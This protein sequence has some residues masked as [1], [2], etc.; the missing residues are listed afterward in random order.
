MLL[1]G[2]DETFESGLLSENGLGLIAVAPE[3]RPAGR[4]IQLLDAF[5]L[6]VDVKAASVKARAGLPG[7]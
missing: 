2:F 4:L 7:L 6:P 1:P 5:L 3:L